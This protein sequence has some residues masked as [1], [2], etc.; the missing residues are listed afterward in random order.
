MSLALELEAA[1]FGRGVE[2]VRAGRGGECLVVWD[3]VYQYSSSSL[4]S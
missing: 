1:L 3:F 4:V 2:G